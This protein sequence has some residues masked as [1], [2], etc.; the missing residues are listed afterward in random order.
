VP[1]RHAA[2]QAQ[3]DATHPDWVVPGTPFTTITVNNTYPTGV[4]TDK[5]DLDAG[6]SNLT[7]VRRGS[8]SGGIFLFP[9]YRVGVDMADGDLLLMDAHEYHGN[10]PLE[11][12]SD[13]AERISVVAYYRTRMVECGNAEQ[14]AD[15]ALAHAD[16]IVTVR[17][18]RA[19]TGATGRDHYLAGRSGHPPGRR[20]RPGRTP[21]A[22]G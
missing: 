17:R 2:Q 18:E 1:D 11:L 16:Q 10:T 15:R 14:E 6:F 13:D 3:V 7:V 5:G 20:A 12:A 9:A 21:P 19:T 8:Y 22:P 4:H